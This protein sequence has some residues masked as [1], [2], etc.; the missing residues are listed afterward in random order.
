MRA[1]KQMFEHVTDPE[2]LLYLD[3]FLA[4]VDDYSSDE[5]CWN[6]TGSRLPK[7]YGSFWF[8]GRL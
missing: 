2:L 3:R 6:W 8:R 4:K 5:I 1:S 7:G